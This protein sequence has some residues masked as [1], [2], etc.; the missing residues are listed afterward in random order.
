M[1]NNTEL[2]MS[3]KADSNPQP[4][5]EI[6]T[7]IA[8]AMGKIRKVGKDNENKFDK[9]NFASIDDFLSLVN[10]IC[11]EA[12]LLFHMQEGVVTEFMKKG[13]NG[14]SSWLRITFEITAYHTS[15]QF[16]PPVFRSVEVQRTGAQA[17]G[18]AQSYAL[19]QFLR[20]LLLI[21]TGD[22]DDADFE[23]TDNGAV[24]QASPA[25]QPKKNGKS[26]TPETRKIFSNLQS[27]IYAAGGDLDA[28]T[29]WGEQAET[30]DAIAQLPADWQNDI[31]GL[32]KSEITAA[33]EPKNMEQAA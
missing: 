3:E 4:I 21:P 11:A 10:P 24:V 32:Y 14:E 28:L 5:G 17:Y 33:K 23:R 19:K 9:Y 13:R 16:L 15:G 2:A 26:K 20:S 22:K 12:G 27:D 25:T 31:R 1:S 18:S 6:L 30:K 29:I 7:A 8:G